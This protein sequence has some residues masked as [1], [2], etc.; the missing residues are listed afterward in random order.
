MVTRESS[1]T[2]NDFLLAVGADGGKMI[3]FTWNTSQDIIIE[4]PNLNRI[5]CFML[6]S[7]VL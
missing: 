6:W 3:V 4:S 2:A 5:G 1:G 7:I